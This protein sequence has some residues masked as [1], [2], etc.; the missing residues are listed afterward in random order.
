[1]RL[2][3]GLIDLSKVDI[4]IV[5][6]ISYETTTE[7]G[8]TALR[9]LVIQARAEADV[10][11]IISFFK[12]EK[13]VIRSGELPIEQHKLGDDY[14]S[15]CDDADVREMLANV[16]AFQSYDETDV[17]DADYEMNQLKSATA[18]D[19]VTKLDVEVV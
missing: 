17:D 14:A 16:F 7:L 4:D 9:R 12:R 13:R 2:N 19:A 6:D 8:T 5:L 11:L 3:K 1:M 15:I 18:S 10:N